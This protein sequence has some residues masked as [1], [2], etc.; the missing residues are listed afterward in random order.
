MQRHLDRKPLY[1]QLGGV[2]FD[3]VRMST[4]TV[5]PQNAIHRSRRIVRIVVFAALPFSRH[6]LQLE[7]TT[8]SLYVL[9]ANEVEVLAQ[10]D[11]DS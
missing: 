6:P 2:G 11:F 7:T 8:A 9:G 4:Y 5:A 10:D 1:N 3:F